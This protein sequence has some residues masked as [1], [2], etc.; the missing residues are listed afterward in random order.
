MDRFRVFLALNRDNKFTKTEISIRLAR[1]VWG[2]LVLI[3]F[4]C[5]AVFA[6]PALAQSGPTPNPN[7]PANEPTLEAPNKISVEPT[8]RDE[9]IRQRLQSILVATGW[10]SNPG[11]QVREGVV[12]LTG[13][14]ATEEYKKWA[15][16]LARNTQD[17]AAVVN[18]IELTQPPIWNFQPALA[19]LQELRLSLVRSIPLILFSLLV[20]LVTW[21]ITRFSISLVRPPLSRRLSNPLLGGV[22]AYTIGILIFLVGL[23]I[24]FQVA[25]LTSVA[26]T[27]LGGTGLIG[28]VLGIAFRDITENFLA[29]IFL[30]VQNPFASGDLV[31]IAGILGFVQALTTRATLLMTL[32]GSHVQIPNATVYK[33]NIHNYTIN[34]HR[35]VD[36]TIG[37]GYD[38]SIT[39][40]QEVA[41]KVLEEHPAV[42]KDPEPW[43]LVDSLGS[44]TVNLRVYFWVDGSQ[45]SWLKVK[46]SVIRLVKRAFQSEAIS[47]PDEAREMIFP[48]GVP[49]RMLA[50]DG[51][52]KTGAEVPEPAVPRQFEESG[53]VSTEAEAGLSSEAEE[54]QEQARQ[55][56]KQE[57]GENLLKPSASD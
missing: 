52:E 32:D 56:R 40:A 25:G 28:L 7:L 13:Q 49:V 1:M 4:V 2:Q 9:Q 53:S 21:V 16:D 48:Q 50:T 3:I 51:A 35:R 41:L 55:S 22:A 20:L 47:M 15:G 27:V 29:S 36:F 54:I 26:L 18:Q 19:G 44:A 46:S 24:V 43:V 39:V 14:T 38:D 57:E 6:T 33:S 30:S 17:V 45:H 12:F 31:E 8:A 37:I 23:Y 10:F 5:S 11:V 34:P 42:L